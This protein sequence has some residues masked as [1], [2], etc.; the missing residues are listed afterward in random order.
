MKQKGIL[1]N[2]LISYVVIV[3][4]YVGA[5]SVLQMKA[6]SILKKQTDT[7]YSHMLTVLS[8]VV[9]NEVQSIKGVSAD[10]VMDSATSGLLDRFRRGEPYDAEKV[11]QVVGK[12]RSVK[13]N[14]WSI[15]T[16]FLYMYDEDKVISSTT[17]ASGELFFDTYLMNLDLTFEEWKENLMGI[18]RNGYH[19]LRNKDGS[20]T[21]MFL[22]PVPMA[23][24]PGRKEGV[25]AIAVSTDVIDEHIRTIQ[26][27]H[28][29]K[30]DVITETGEMVVGSVI[31]NPHDYQMIERISDKTGWSYQT[32]VP[33]ASFRQQERL[34][35]MLALGIIGTATVFGA[36]I[37]YYSLRKNYTPLRNLIVRMEKSIEG[38]DVS[39]NEVDYLWNSFQIM[40]EKQKDDEARLGHQSLEMKSLFI[41]QSFHGR[42]VSERMEEE[43]LRLFRLGF[44]NEAFVVIKVIPWNEDPQLVE[45]R[46]RGDGI[47][48][49]G[50]QM[51]SGGRTVEK[52]DYFYLM[53]ASEY[54]MEELAAE[55]ERFQEACS[56]KIVMSAIHRGSEEIAQAYSEVLG[57]D[58]YG[59]ASGGKNLIIYSGD[60][61]RG[62]AWQADYGAAEK[63]L[64]NIVSARQK[65]EAS[66]CLD[67]I[68]ELI[69]KEGPVSIGEIKFL[70]MGLFNR[71]LGESGDRENRS[72]I[73]NCSKKIRLV[74][75]NGS[76]QKIRDISYETI[77]ALCREVIEETSRE[78]L[79]RQQVME[80]IDSRYTDPD[81][82]VN[83]ICRELERSSSSVMK[84]FGGGNGVL[85]YI[86]ERRIQEAKRIILRDN[87]QVGIAKVA[88]EAGY[89][90]QNTF[91]RVFKKYEGITPGKF[92]E[93]V[94][95]LEE[96][97]I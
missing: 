54:A 93:L 9:D 23:N 28:N 41:G 40:V 2:L 21:V 38:Q 77:E 31:E 78:T 12:L 85:Y 97:K 30:I 49:D 47:Y 16:I 42:M 60:V 76:V 58:G 83:S 18:S 36:L 57:T 84:V 11:R 94:K 51:F 61:L 14:A 50:R 64:V 86:N 17:A 6:V 90:N 33:F 45:D 62:A 80:L 96:E 67:E 43:Y 4:I 29:I 91:I 87:G 46:L 15:D 19:V 95:R 3:L 72:I 44:V 65:E 10:I 5:W 74:S 37:I 34:F 25:L 52:D 73:L 32:Y 71:I 81:L 35:V 70:I 92:C 13:S 59:E 88:E 1:R 24:I 66:A 22:Q 89:A 48:L 27:D 75:G 56:C 55:L 68:W 20:S 53:D 82:S 39:E 63:K 79:L 7:I 26:Q 8:S 69:Y